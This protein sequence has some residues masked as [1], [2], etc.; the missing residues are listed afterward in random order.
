MLLVLHPQERPTGR[1]GSIGPTPRI[2]PLKGPFVVAA[3]VP[4]I[5]NRAG[6]VTIGKVLLFPEH[7]H[8][9]IIKR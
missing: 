3:V 8:E 1:R 7:R 4:R 9:R 5:P 2:Y 6:I